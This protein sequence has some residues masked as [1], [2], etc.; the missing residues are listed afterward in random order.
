MRCTES[1]LRGPGYPWRPAVRRQ[2]ARNA[3][4]LL[5]AVA[6]SGTCRGGRPWQAGAARWLRL[7]RKAR[8]DGQGGS[9][10]AATAMAERVLIMTVPCHRALAALVIWSLIQTGCFRSSSPRPEPKMVSSSRHF[11]SSPG[12]GRNKAGAAKKTRTTPK[13][14]NGRQN[15]RPVLRA[16][17]DSRPCLRAQRGAG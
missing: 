11:V 8:Q 1:G 10:H 9:K 16:D 13:W 12:S 3:A 5:R 4:R 7:R 2:E 6:A 15:I 17:L 14:F